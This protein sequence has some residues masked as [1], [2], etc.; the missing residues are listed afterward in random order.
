MRGD[1]GRAG[2]SMVGDGRPVVVQDRMAISTT[3]PTTGEIEKTF[4]ALTDA[5]VDERIA[6]AAATAAEYRHTTFEQRAAWMRAAADQ[7]EAACEEIARIMTTEM[8]KT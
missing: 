1:P 6:R 3:N 4:E 5:E 2:S 7:L 8:G